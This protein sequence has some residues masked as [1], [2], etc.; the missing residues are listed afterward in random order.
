MARL[1]RSRVR[2]AGNGG[3]PAPPPPSSAPPAAPASAGKSTTRIVRKAPPPVEG[4]LSVPQWTEIIKEFPDYAQAYLERGII[5][6]K[7][8][9]YDNALYDFGMAL[10]LNPA[11]TKPI[12]WRGRTYVAFKK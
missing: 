2:P 6:Y 5:L 11:D 12:Y 10:K 9:R 3:A 4:S 8:N 1:H 7:S